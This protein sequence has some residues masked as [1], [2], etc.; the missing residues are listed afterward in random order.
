MLNNV[1]C[2]EN[3]INNTTNRITQRQFLQNDYKPQ[4]S[5]SPELTSSTKLPYLSK[6]LENTDRQVYGSSNL[7]EGYSDKIYP[8]KNTYDAKL[9]NN[10][11]EF[12][13]SL[14]NLRSQVNGE[15]QNLSFRLNKLKFESRR[16]KDLKDE[17]KRNMDKSIFQIRDR[18]Q[19]SM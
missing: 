5:T 16:V 17:E 4:F 13:R 1:F 9:A 7:I 3:N 19:F 6:A 12:D 14:V 11:N 2:R 8:F 15:Y 10:L 18:D